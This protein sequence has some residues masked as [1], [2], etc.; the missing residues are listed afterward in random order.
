[1]AEFMAIEIAELIE[2]GLEFAGD[3]ADSEA[4]VRESQ[5]AFIEFADP[6]YRAGPLGLALIGRDGDPRVAL[7]HWMQVTADSPSGRFEAAARL[8]GISEALARMVELNH[9]GGISAR[10]I[11]RSLRVGALG[12]VMT[13]PRAAS[14]PA[15]ARPLQAKAAGQH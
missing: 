12:M 14:R 11:A 6:T 2:R 1:M 7:D 15:H 9:R 13:D 10:A 3:G 5:R 4:R 8:L